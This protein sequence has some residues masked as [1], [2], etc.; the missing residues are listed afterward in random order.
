MSQMSQSH[1]A[2]IFRARLEKR[3]RKFSSMILVSQ[4][5][6]VF[7]FAEFATFQASQVSLSFL[8]DEEDD[9]HEEAG[10]PV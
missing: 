10:R 7:H 9:R 6:Q 5:S 8:H 4:M 3:V 1:R 2:H